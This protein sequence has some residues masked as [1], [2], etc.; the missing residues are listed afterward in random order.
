MFSKE[1]DATEKEKFR[2][3]AIQLMQSREARS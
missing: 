3:L 2:S 1:R